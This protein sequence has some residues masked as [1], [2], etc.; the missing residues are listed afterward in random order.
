M[1][2]V[3][4]APLNLETIVQSVRAAVR[5]SPDAV[6]ILDKDGRI[7]TAND[8]LCTALQADDSSLIG[9]PFETTVGAIDPTRFWSRCDDAMA[10][11][12]P[13][14]RSTGVDPA[15]TEFVA[16]VTQL[17]LRI[18]GLEQ[19]SQ[20]SEDLLRIAGRVARCGG[21]SVDPGTGEVSL[22]PG[23]R[24]LLG[25]ADDEP[26]LTATA[27]ARH[28]D[29][30]RTRVDAA[31]RSCCTDGT[32]FDLASIMF[33]TDG[34][35][36]TIRTV[37]EAQVSSDG[38]I[39]GSHGAI[40]DVSEM[41][42][43]RMREREW[44]TRLTE[45]L[46]ALTDG[47]LFVDHDD[48]VSLANPRAV[49][50]I[51][52]VHGDLRGASTGELFS[53]DTGAGFR[54]SF[55]RGKAKGEQTQH[56]GQIAIAGRWGEIIAYP[57]RDGLGVYLRDVTDDEEANA[58]SRRVQQQLQQQAALLDSAQNAMVVRDL[59]NRTQFW[60]RAATELY[61]WSADEIISRWVGDCLYSD[62]SVLERATEAVWRDGYFVE[63]VEQLTRD[64]RTVVVDCRWQL[65]TDDAGQLQS[66]FVVNTDIALSRR[67]Q[68]ERLQ[69]RRI[70]VEDGSHGVPPR[71]GRE[72]FRT[73]F[74]D[75]RCR[76]GHRARAR[77][78]HLH[79]NRA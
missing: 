13:R 40:W 42:A 23:G 21:W 26:P 4:R 34:D 19:E 43:A 32:P 14:Y 59:D 5:D 7:L 38:T 9:M 79:G 47:V 64:G 17:P 36:L 10:G 29:E 28:S 41:A 75:K 77:A 78:R 55:G 22:S 44:E 6:F 37:D 50:P 68:D 24:A 8:V 45:T 56:R 63:E 53:A 70:A 20:K 2:G 49:D 65:I 15:G 18:D 71:C 69:A 60:S 46:N 35:Q 76:Q 30:S 62:A 73:V 25:I 39:G 48:A 27:R 31:L 66:I 33:A 72:D 67:E 74:H 54:A 51:S 11:K 61:G 12:R 3:E 16:E 58:A 57:T 52:Q 1:T